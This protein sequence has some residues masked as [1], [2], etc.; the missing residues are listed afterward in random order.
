[1]SGVIEPKAEAGATADAS[2][3]THA[4]AH[5]K[6]ANAMAIPSLAPGP[7]AAFD[8]DA[9]DESLPLLRDLMREYGDIYRVPTST[10]A[11][12]GLVIHG[13]DD[14]RRVLLTNRANYTKGVGLERV[15]VL[16]GNGLIVSDGDTWARQRRMMQPAFHSRVIKSFATL[17]H[18][19]NAG[20]IERWSKA[21][22]TGETVNMTHDLSAAALSIVLHSLFSVDLDRLV[23]AQGENPFDLLTRETRR[24]MPF[25]AKFRALTRHVRA[26]IESRR[27]EDRIEHDFLSMLMEAR[28]KE[29]GEPMNDRA[30]LDEIMTLIVAGHETTAGTLNWA[31]YLIS[32]NP[33][34]E[35]DLHAAID[36]LV[37]DPT[38]E[39]V[40]LPKSPYVEQ[41]INEAMRLYPSVWLLGR[42]AIAD[43]VL[44]GYRV[45]AG[46]D[47]FICPYLL[48][49]HSAHWSDVDAFDPHRFA[50]QASSGR[51]PFS[52]LPFSSG[53]RHCIGAGFAMAEMATHMVMVGQR[54]RLQ[55][56]APSAPEAEFQINLRTREDLQMRVLTRQAQ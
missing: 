20:L 53:P 4:T 5:A 37:I 7:S 26:M 41:L 45:P 24:D 1:M 27:T 42:R 54:F 15:R 2:A 43:D 31:W 16:L 25:A 11:S 18:R 12:D 50:D 30:L 23:E 19:V 17:M 52:F 47:I 44:S 22:E 28:D 46:T 36:G 56:I 8:I 48:H 10:R 35:A 29:T 6:T 33:S 39:T 21:A 51:H 55:Y 40:T 38:A 32:Q 9:N 34:V 49:R 3:T 13:A 14:I